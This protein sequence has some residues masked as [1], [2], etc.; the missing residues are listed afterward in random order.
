MI[1]KIKHLEGIPSKT[2]AKLDQVG[3]V[4]SQK[5]WNSSFFVRTIAVIKG[6]TNRC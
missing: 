2:D 3:L 4:M 6:L 1:M 5:M